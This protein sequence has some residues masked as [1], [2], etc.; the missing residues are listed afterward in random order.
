MAI[1]YLHSLLHRV[2]RGWDPISPMHA[3]E[4]TEAVDAA[5]AQIFT[6][7]ISR[8]RS[9]AGSLEGKRVLDLGGGPGRHSVIFANCGALVTWH[10]VS[11]EYERIARRRAEAAGVSI[12]LSLGC[13]E[14]AAQ[15]GV[16]SFDLVFCSL[17]WSYSRSDRSFARL[18]YTLI[19][20]GGIGYIACDTSAPSKS[21]GI[22]RLQYW[23]NVHLWWKIG[24]PMP[25][26][27][28]IAALI[29]KYPIS[30]MELDYRSKDRDIVIFLKS[31]LSDTSS[32]KEQCE[33]SRYNGTALVDGHGDRI[34]GK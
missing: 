29:Q 33:Q 28:R 15:F 4:Y 11:R 13:L 7:P 30:Y 2:E 26:H 14:K 16:G 3:K 25:P 32:G 34:S 23:L 20:P 5:P 21:Q 8:L 27:G 19:K 24:H 1:N 10:D 9:L 17:S 18:L 22:R 6:S 12:Q 31:K